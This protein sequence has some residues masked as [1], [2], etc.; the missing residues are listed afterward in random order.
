M[1]KRIGNITIDL[2]FFKDM[3]VGTLVIISDEKTGPDSFARAIVCD[4]SAKFGGFTEAIVINPHENVHPNGEPW[5]AGEKFSSLNQNV[6]VIP[7]T[8]EY[9]GDILIE[10]HFMQCGRLI[11][12]AGGTEK[13]HHHETVYAIDQ[14]Y[15]APLSLRTIKLEPPSIG[16]L[17][18]GTKVIIQD[19]KDRYAL[20][21]FF[22]DG[23]YTEYVSIIKPYHSSRHT[24]EKIYAPGNVFPVTESAFAGILIDQFFMHDGELWR[25]TTTENAMARIGGKKFDP[26]IIVY[27]IDEKYT[28]ADKQPSKKE[29]KEKPS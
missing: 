27:A 10:Q 5:K 29:R 18:E 6:V 13:Y 25:K 14:K 22:L 20:A 9:F 24:G 1:R 8:E 15:I 28:H 16:E 12:E 7:V 26:E 4:K 19:E 2:P 3:E 21:K 17:K 23:T 11:I